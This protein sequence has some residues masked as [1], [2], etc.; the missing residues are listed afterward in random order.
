MKV[1]TVQYNPCNWESGFETLSLHTNKTN[2]YKALL[3]FKTELFISRRENR[4]L[5]GASA[6]GEK[7]LQ[8]WEL[9]RVQELLVLGT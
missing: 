5:Y 8:G 1:F 7:Y 9:F 4:I 6:R 3:R 2:A